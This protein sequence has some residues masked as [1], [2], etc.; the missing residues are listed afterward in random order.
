MSDDEAF[1]RH[2]RAT[3]GKPKVVG[4]PFAKGQSG[5]P[6]GRPKVIKPLQDLAREHTV[7]ALQTLVSVMKNTEQPGAARVAAAQAVLDRGY[8]KAAQ[9]LQVDATDDFRDMVEALAGHERSSFADA[10]AAA[11]VAARDA[12]GD[13]TAAAGGSVH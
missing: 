12:G 11:L 4:K 10:I 8:G 2:L 7:D 3:A 9:V 6:T 13:A 5:N 1:T